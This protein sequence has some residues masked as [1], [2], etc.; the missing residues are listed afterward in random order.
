MSERTL[1]RLCT[2]Q[3]G[4]SFG[5]WRRQLHMILALRDLSAGATVQQVSYGLGYESPSAF[6]TMFKKAFGKP[7]ATYVS[8]R[9]RAGD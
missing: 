5:R 4:L 7:P 2:A 8:D 6:I 3:T 1:N 9:W